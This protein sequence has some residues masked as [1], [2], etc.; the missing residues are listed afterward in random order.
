MFNNECN[1]NIY[2]K[3]LIFVFKRR[4]IGLYMLY[5]IQKVKR[6]GLIQKVTHAHKIKKILFGG[7]FWE[8]KFYIPVI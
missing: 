7:I 5:F 4:I 2:R 8:H 6:R 3:N 1:K